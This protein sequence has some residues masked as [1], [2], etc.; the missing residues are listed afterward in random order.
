[1]VGA[2]FINP[3]CA[4]TVK[5]MVVEFVSLSIHLSVKSHL[6][7][8]ASVRPEI[9]VTYS[10]GNKGTKICGDSS[11][12]A[13]LR[14]YTASCIVRLYPCSPPFY[15]IKT[16]MRIVFLPVSSTAEAV[17]GQLCVPSLPKTQPTNVASLC[18]TVLVAR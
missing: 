14:R 17:E 4:C 10:T 15:S 9:D 2:R 18:V 1:M 3:R 11:E 5:I 16:R 7:T 13:P 6:T 8:G 12:T